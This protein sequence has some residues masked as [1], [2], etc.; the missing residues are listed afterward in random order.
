MAEG[1]PRILLPLSVTEVSVGRP[2]EELPFFLPS[3]PVVSPVP[4]LPPPP[5]VY[6]IF[7]RKN[8]VGVHTNRFKARTR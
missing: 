6:I 3:F 5:Q 7:I 1:P 8:E 2:I 4:P